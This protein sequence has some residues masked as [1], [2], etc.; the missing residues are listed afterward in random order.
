[1]TTLDGLS[2]RLWKQYE[3]D[4]FVFTYP[5]TLQQ[6]SYYIS[7]VYPIEYHPLDSTVANLPCNYPKGL[8]TQGFGTHFNETDIA[9]DQP[10]TLVISTANLPVQ[11]QPD[12]MI[13]GI[14]TSFTITFE[15]CAGQDSMMLWIDGVFQPPDKYVYTDMG[16]YGQITL[17]TPP[18]IGQELWVWYLPLG[19]ACINERVNELTVT[20]DPQIF[21][22]PDT[23][24]D[25]PTL[26]AYLEGL[27]ILQGQDYSVINSNT[28][29]QFG[30]ITPASGQSL[31]AH[32]NLGLIPP[33]DKWRQ[34]YVGTTDGVLDT[35]MTPHLLLSE[36]PTS[37]DSVLVF[38]DGL[39]QGGKYAV[40]VDGFGNPTGN[41]I[42]TGG[43]PEANRRLDVVY[44]RN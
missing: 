12:G 7:E 27:F 31:W 37:V 41:I 4:K 8:F 43:A 26:V 10:G 6:E 38:L 19:T 2:T 18:A 40:E 28:Q 21:D 11:E 5:P 39:N 32:Y 16:S 36:L 3:G 33:V 15:S 1:V 42:F 14:N 29:I 35:F 20:L 25:T 44:I 13:D 22:V 24:T 17:F 23:W 9:V 30:T 34:V